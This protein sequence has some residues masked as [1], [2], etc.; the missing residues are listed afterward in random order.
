MSKTDRKERIRAMLDAEKGRLDD[1]N[2]NAFRHEMR[3]GIEMGEIPELHIAQRRPWLSY[4]APIAA[5]CVIAIGLFYWHLGQS[6]TTQ[7]TF[8][9]EV[10][11]TSANLAL[12]PG[13]A[14]RKGK[15]EIRLLAG[16]ATLSELN[17][18]FH[19][20]G[21]ELRADFLLREKT[22]L[23]IEHPLVTVQV[24][25]T[26]FLFDARATRGRIDLREG[27]LRVKYHGRQGKEK[28]VLLV[29][30]AK[31]IFSERGY[32]ES[33]EKKTGLEQDKPLFRYELVSGEVFYAE[34]LSLSPT[35]HRV[36]LLGGKEQTIRVADITSVTRTQ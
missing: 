13:E 25:G 28:E 11:K 10:K 20:T 18:R 32:T 14:Y 19:I 22:D 16:Q 26:Q 5:A 8:T 24:T 6:R 34:Q 35:E 17:Q 7:P 12:R 9:E 36:Q 30:P 29:A 3:K 21:R 27:R 31:F 2:W 1:Q 15:R 23:V 33:D 4:L